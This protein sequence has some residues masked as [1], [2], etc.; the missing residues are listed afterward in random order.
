MVIFSEHSY[1][2]N[3]DPLLTEAAT[4]HILVG[5]ALVQNSNEC[6]NFV[7]IAGK[8]ETTATLHS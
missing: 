8:Y 2:I 1:E 5:V 3:P 6:V 4:C 7:K